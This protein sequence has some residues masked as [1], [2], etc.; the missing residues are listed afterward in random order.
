MVDAM[1]LVT[2][3]L[4]KQLLYVSF[5]GE[6]R[7]EAFPPGRAELAAVLQEFSPGFRYLVDFSQLVAMDADCAVEIGLTMDFIREAGVGQLARV[8]PDPTKDIGIN[9]L[10]LFH[11]PHELKVTNHETLAEALQ[12][13]GF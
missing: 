10:T 3:N 5:V 9:I 6:V 2:V 12:A 8:I 4:S 13:L 7:P 1:L 11:Y